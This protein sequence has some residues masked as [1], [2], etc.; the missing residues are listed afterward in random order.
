MVGAAINAST[1]GQSAMTQALSSYDPGV[2]QAM[3]LNAR[4]A[5]KAADAP[6]ADYQKL[7]GAEESQKAAQSAERTA[8]AGQQSHLLAEQE[9]NK[10]T[11]KAMEDLKSPEARVQAMM[12]QGNKSPAEAIA[13][14]RVIQRYGPQGL[15]PRTAGGAPEAAGQGG[16][17]V[18]GREGDP[19]LDRVYQALPTAGPSIEE[20]LTKNSEPGPALVAIRNNLGHAF[21]EK[22]IGNILPA[23]EAKYGKT[24]VAN[25]LGLQGGIM[26]RT[27]LGTSSK[28]GPRSSMEGLRRTFFSPNEE[29]QVASILRGHLQRSNQWPYRR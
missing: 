27:E 12:L 14:E 19:A 7:L 25:F 3:E 4:M 29:D 6:M 18:A 26:D 9:K 2:G 23:I 8:L 17:A 16:A 20:A 5:Q 13:A 22:N 10:L 11:A 1:A 15:K 21:L 24:G 28:P